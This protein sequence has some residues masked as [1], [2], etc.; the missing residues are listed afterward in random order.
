MKAG[1]VVK[2]SL[3]E[4]IALSEKHKAKEEQVV[5]I[6]RRIEAK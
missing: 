3:P 6:P 5:V 1:E 2:L 4:R